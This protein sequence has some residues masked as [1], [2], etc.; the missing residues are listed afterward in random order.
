MN[1]DDVLYQ[2]INGVRDIWM[3]RYRLP[4]CLEEPMQP[5]YNI[6]KHLLLDNQVVVNSYYSNKYFLICDRS[7]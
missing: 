2:I 1:D 7:L 6:K 5:K 4:I 3:D